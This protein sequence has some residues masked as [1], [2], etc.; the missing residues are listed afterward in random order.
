MEHDYSIPNID[1]I[2]VYYDLC[3]AFVSNIEAAMIVLSWQ[4][5]DYYVEECKDIEKSW[6]SIELQ[7]ENDAKIIYEID[8]ENEIVI[9]SSEIDDF[10]FCLRC[11]YLMNIRSAYPNIGYYFDRI[12]GYYNNKQNK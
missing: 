7:I 12:E 10:A 3:L 8:R 9:K 5:F 1:E 4:H 11:I 6:L 2:D